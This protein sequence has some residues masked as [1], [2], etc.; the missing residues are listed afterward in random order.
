MDGHFWLPLSVSV[1]SFGVAIWSVL[2]AKNSSKNSQRSADEAAAAQRQIADVL[3][4][5]L[6]PRP[7]WEL[8]PNAGQGMAYLL[9]NVGSAPAHEVVLDL[10]RLGPSHLTQQLRWPIVRVKETRPF[11]A[12]RGWE[13]YDDLVS[14]SWLDPEQEGG[15]AVWQGVLPHHPPEPPRQR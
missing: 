15:R 3:A 7:D 1:L 13:S 6:R 2:A 10:G 5:G 12:V 8:Q 4:A 11:M 9:V 14:I